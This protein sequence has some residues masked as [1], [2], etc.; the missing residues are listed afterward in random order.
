MLVRILMVRSLVGS[1][2][3]QRLQQYCDNAWQ[4]WHAGL[5]VAGQ[6]MAASGLPDKGC[7]GQGVTAQ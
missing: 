6:L 4:I 2:G 7:S 1:I 3:P 5:C